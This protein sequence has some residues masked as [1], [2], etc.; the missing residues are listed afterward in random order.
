[1]LCSLRSTGYK[2]IVPHTQL[3]TKWFTQMTKTVKT[4]FFFICYHPSSRQP[5]GKVQ[6]F[7]PEGWGY[8]EG[9]QIKTNFSLFSFVCMC[10]CVRS[11]SGHVKQYRW[12]L[13]FFFFKVWIPWFFCWCSVS[14]VLY[15]FYITCQTKQNICA[16]W[17]V[18][19]W[20]LRPF[21]CALR[22]G[23]DLQMRDKL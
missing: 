8:S 2:I 21:L 14:Q 18:P 19:G 17:K 6:S 15:I 3:A 13:L 4:L 5:A 16:R 22:W 10:V 7:G 1:M 12:L 23:I 9:G 11:I 20:E